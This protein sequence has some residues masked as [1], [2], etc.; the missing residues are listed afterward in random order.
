[1]QKLTR[2]DK[3][4]KCPFKMYT[5]PTLRLYR[6]LGL[7]RQTYDAG[8]DADKGDYLVLNSFETTKRV[9]KRAVQMMPIR[10]PG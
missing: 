7:T 2:V 10:N 4:F 3:A 9:M 8:D 1:M 6:A 5:D